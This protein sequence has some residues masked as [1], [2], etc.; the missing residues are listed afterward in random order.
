MH[1]GY[2]LLAFVP[3]LV[4]VA[5]QAGW[6]TGSTVFARFVI[7][8]VCIA[9]VSPLGGQRLKTGN[10]RALFLRGLFGGGA[11]LAYFAAVEE[12]N[13]STAVLLNFT[14]SIWAN[15]IGVLVLRQ[16]PVRGFWPL[17]SLAA[18]G[19]YLVI[20][21]GF[22]NFKR[23]EMLG[24][25]S[26]VLGGG[27]ILCVKELRKTDNATTIQASLSLAGLVCALPFFVPARLRSPTALLDDFSAALPP[28]LHGPAGPLASPALCAWLAVLAM[29]IC[30]YAGQHFF[31]SGYKD[32][33]VQLGTLLSLTTPLYATLMG[34]LLLQEVLTARFLLGASFIL[35]AC[36]LVGL[37]ERQA[38]TR[39]GK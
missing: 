13:A 39:G 8:C 3:V 14:H 6:D 1:T 38:L 27:A 28:V 16:K 32:T 20:D 30:A 17:L 37:K 23:G 33:S 21:P 7:A 35:V 5:N 4:R 9:V 34:R 31:T 10:P 15:V 26:G 18:V 19:L 2:L 25:L 12:T 36:M 24:L 22:D 11:V 29:G